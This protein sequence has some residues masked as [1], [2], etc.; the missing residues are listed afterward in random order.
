MPDGRMVY[1]RFIDYVSM[2][3]NNSY[4]IERN[5]SSSSP[6]KYYKPNGL[7]GFIEKV[8]LNVSSPYQVE[9]NGT[10]TILDDFK[11]E[12]FVYFYIDADANESI[13]VVDTG[14]G[15]NSIP[16]DQLKVSGPGYQP[17]TP[18]QA[19]EDH[20]DFAKLIQTHLP[21]EKFLLLGLTFL[22]LTTGTVVMTSI[23]PPWNSIRLTVQFR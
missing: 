3:I 13:T 22:P 9:E 6:Y 14:L 10:V 7:Y 1:R 5:Q 15:I 12:A 18:F 20:G 21:K 8:D 16:V 17:E 19:Q 23:F 4:F 2:D 11:A